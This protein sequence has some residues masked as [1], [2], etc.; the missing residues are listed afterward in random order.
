[1][2]LDPALLSTLRVGELPPALFSLTDNLVHEVGTDLKKGTVQELINLVAP[3][4]SALQFQVIE[5]DVPISYI[6]ANF[7][8]TGLGTNLCLGY[9]ICNG[10]NGTK[11]RNGLISLGYGV[12]YTAIGGLGGSAT[13]VLTV[14]NIPPLQVPYNGS[15]DDNGGE[16]LLIV[17]SGAQFNTTKNLVTGGTGTAHNIMQPY[18]ITLMIQKL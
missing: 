12:G 13:N 6:T 3:L 5:L 4:V 16:G 7:D 18:I 9:A 11:N 17:T 8:N 14:A 1:M 2:A 10:N 15:N